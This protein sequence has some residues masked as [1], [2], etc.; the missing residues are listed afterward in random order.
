[1]S[2]NMNKPHWMAMAT[3]AEFCKIHTN[4]NGVI[5]CKGCGSIEHPSVDH[6][7]PRINNGRDDLHNLQPL[8]VPCN[9]RKGGR[10]DNYWSTGKYFDRPM[11]RENLRIS[12]DDYVYSPIMEYRDFFAQPWSS[13][14]RKLFLYAQIVG[15]GKTLGMFALPFALNQARGMGVPR[16]DKMLIITKDTSLRSQTANE[17]LTEPVEYGIVGEAPRVIELTKGADFFSPE[18]H[19]IAIMCPNMIWPDKDG[20]MLDENGVSQNTSVDWTKQAEEVVKRYPL[21]IFDEVHYAYQQIS[22]FLNVAAQS[23]VFG[24]T[25]SPIDG[26]GELLEDMVRMSVYGYHEAKINDKSMKW[27]GEST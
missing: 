5:P 19:D 3:W 24:F 16:I 25:A 21:I 9:S 1:M 23:L 10:P 8:C 2:M 15:A 11:H 13:I 4:D 17:L 14:N 26:D 20:T 12:Q 18:A 27:L 7:V 22:G 6:I